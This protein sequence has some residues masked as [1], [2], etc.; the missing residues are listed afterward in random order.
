[1]FLTA[2]YAGKQAVAISTFWTATLVEEKYCH[3]TPILVTAQSVKQVTVMEES[4]NWIFSKSNLVT[5][6]MFNKATGVLQYPN[7]VVHLQDYD[8]SLRDKR[9]KP[10]NSNARTN[11][12]LK[13]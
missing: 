11:Q 10:A 9:D 5:D 12:H 13:N 1:M 7:T 3:P 6:L 8:R 4:F 2:S